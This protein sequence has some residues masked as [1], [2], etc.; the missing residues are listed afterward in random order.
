MA[1]KITAKQEAFIQAYL[2]N[3]RNATSAYKHSYD[4]S[5]MSEASMSK[6][7]QSLLK[8]PLIAP[9]ISAIVQMTCERTEVTVERVIREYARIAFADMR[10]FTKWGSA[11]MQLKE[12]DGLSDDDASAVAEISETAQGLKIKLHDKK[13]ALDS[14]AKNLGMFIDKTEMSGPGGASLIPV[15][16]VTIAK[17]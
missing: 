11:G 9:R 2:T 13:G 5:T 15:I 6:E 16:N 14:L 8:H 12:G 10:S 3:G 17:D 7:A 4:C 1:R